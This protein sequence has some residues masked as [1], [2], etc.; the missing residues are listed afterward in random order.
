[1]PIRVPNYEYSFLHEKNGND[2]VIITAYNECSLQESNPGL[3]LGV[4]GQP[5]NIG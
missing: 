1:V 4:Q 2:F 5:E 3:S